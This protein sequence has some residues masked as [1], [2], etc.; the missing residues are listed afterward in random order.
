MQVQGE[1]VRTQRRSAHAGSKGLR[2][3][4]LSTGGALVAA[5]M[6]VA[7]GIGAVAA[8][9]PAHAPAPRWT[10]YP[11]PTPESG[12]CVNLPG[13]DGAEWFEETIAK[14][15]GRIDID[16]GKVEEFPVPYFIGGYGGGEAGAKRTIDLNG[17]PLTTF[18]C[19]IMNGDDGLI[20]FSNGTPN[21][22]VS[23]DPYSKKMAIYNAPHEL[24]NVEPFNDITLGTD[25]AVWST[26][27]TSNEIGRFDEYTHE[28]TDFKIP[29]PGALPIG[30]HMGPDNAVWFTE[31][32][33]GKI[34]RLD[35]ATHEI[36]EYD[37]ESPTSLPF[38][39]RATTENRYIWWGEN[40]GNYIGRMDTLTRK[41]TEY[42]IPNPIARPGITCEKHNMIYFNEYGAN[43]IGKLDPRTGKFTELAVPGRGDVPIELRCGWGN[44]LWFPGTVGSRMIRLS[45]DGDPL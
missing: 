13:M 31:G 40:Q 35:L 45:L 9:A 8:P 39:I 4:A 21:Q 12:P 25:H 17:T 14:K 33:N 41:I 1:S 16:T 36:T 26:E 37:T 3:S 28:W 5:V 29:T 27:S 43:A 19:A 11:T 2:R 6:T 23:I 24:G 42:K 20:Y 32:A 38:V 7:S 10:F 34:G 22:I 44:A 15:V 30:M 18:T